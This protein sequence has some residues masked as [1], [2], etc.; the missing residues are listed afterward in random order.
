MDTFN[1]CQMLRCLL[2][3][4]ALPLLAVATSPAWDHFLTGLT[5]FPSFQAGLRYVVNHESVDT[6]HLLARDARDAPLSLLVSMS[7]PVVPTITFV[8]Q[9]HQIEFEHALAEANETLA[10]NT[11]VK[12]ESY[13][14]LRRRAQPKLAGHQIIV[15][16]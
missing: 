2:L 1:F 14:A 4:A 11:V 9:L 7:S 16:R 15:V 8:P 13:E 3:L 12:V 6:V 10:L 5:G